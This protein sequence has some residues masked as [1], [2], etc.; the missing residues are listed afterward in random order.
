MVF[1]CT[2]TGLPDPTE[3]SPDM[4]VIPDPASN[5]VVPRSVIPL[6][7]ALSVSIELA[8]SVLPSATLTLSLIPP[9]AVSAVPSRSPFNSRLATAD[10]KD[11]CAKT[12][13]FACTVI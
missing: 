5:V 8:V 1:A 6:V 3:A 7:D 12:P 9:T 4:M 10:C 2:Y 13:L 11:T